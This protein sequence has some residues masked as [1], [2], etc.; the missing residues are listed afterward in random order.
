[1]LGGIGPFNAPV[2]D[3][4]AG[5]TTWSSAPSMTEKR[6]GPAATTA[7]GGSPP[8][9]QRHSRTHFVDFREN[10]RQ[11]GVLTPTRL[12]LFGTLLRFLTWPPELL[13]GSL[14]RVC[15][16]PAA[17][18]R[19]LLRTVQL[20]RSQ[21]DPLRVF[22]EQHTRCAGRIF[23]AGGLSGDFVAE[24]SVEM[25]DVASGLAWSFAPSLV[26]KLLKARLRCPGH[27]L[28]GCAI[29]MRA[30]AAADQYD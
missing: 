9:P 7:L 13:P 5:A 27:R 8:G 30:V 2:L 15:R 23:V 28:H 11:R 19:Q 14:A 20:Q 1:M 6:F 18:T 26:N 16:L 12:T 29:S 17:T 22:T 3:V 4:E 25:L 10:L 21:S 24:A